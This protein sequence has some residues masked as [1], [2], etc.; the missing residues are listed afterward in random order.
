MTSGRNGA[1]AYAHSCLLLVFVRK[2]W[3]QEV[4]FVSWGMENLFLSFI[5]KAVVWSSRN[6]SGVLMEERIIH[7]T[8]VVL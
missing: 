6:I 3:P 8:S 5:E 1:E 7:R 2:D 4:Q